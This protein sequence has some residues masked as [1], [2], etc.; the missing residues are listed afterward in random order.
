M[1]LVN[2]QRDSLSGTPRSTADLDLD[3][4]AA[5]VADA[6]RRVNSADHAH[7]LEPRLFASNGPW[8]TRRKPRG[9][10]TE[11]F[12]LLAVSVEQMAMTGPLK[13]ILVMGAHAGEGRTTVTGNLALALAANGRRVVV[14]D[15]DTRRPA[16]ARLFGVEGAMAGTTT[17]AA[18]NGHVGASNNGV[19]S[20]DFP[21]VVGVPEVPGLALVSAAASPQGPL[22]MAVATPLLAALRSVADFVVIDTPPCAEY[23]DAFHMAPLTHGVVYVVRRRQQDVD[24]QRRA[25]DLLGRLGTSVLAAVFNDC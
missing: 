14:M 18:S 24:A 3:L 5:R 6:C 22:D 2:D 8:S 4:F 25:H 9:A 17:N 15:A 21:R 10:F 19:Q 20:D 23:S 13:T 12:R 16:L 11:A 7:V 1:S